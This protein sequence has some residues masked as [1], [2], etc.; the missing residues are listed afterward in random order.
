[1]KL[2]T[3]HVIYQKLAIFLQEKDIYVNRR[4]KSIIFATL[5]CI[6]QIRECKGDP[7]ELNFEGLQMKQ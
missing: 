5:M 7:M 3:K 6:L 1:M 2:G 4:L